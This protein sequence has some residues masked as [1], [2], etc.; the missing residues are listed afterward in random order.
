MASS[1]GLASLVPRPATWDESSGPESGAHTYLVATTIRPRAADH[2][3][4]GRCKCQAAGRACSCRGSWECLGRRQARNVAGRLR[5]TLPMPLA[6][7]RQQ[8]LSLISCSWL[9]GHHTLPNPAPALRRFRHAP[10]MTGLALLVLALPGA[11]ASP[12]PKR[13]STCTSMV[14]PA[15]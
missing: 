9:G 14:R 5:P 7:F 6:P 8:S 1:V 11:G 2:N 15:D 12:L 3:S 4:H 10:A 13:K